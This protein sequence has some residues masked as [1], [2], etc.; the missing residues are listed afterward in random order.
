MLP[1]KPIRT[2]ARD[3]KY[4]H[5]ATRYT[6]QMIVEHALHA[7]SVLH[8][9]HSRCRNKTRQGLENT[10]EQQPNPACLARNKRT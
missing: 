5:F 7:Q 6:Q 9:L 4:R 2:F 8:A 3:P 1:R 10:G